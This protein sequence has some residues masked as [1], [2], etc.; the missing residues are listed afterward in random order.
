MT[1]KLVDATDIEGKLNKSLVPLD[2]MNVDDAF[3]IQPY[4]QQVN[5][6]K[7]EIEEL[8]AE[9]ADRSLLIQELENCKDQAR[10]ELQSFYER[11]ILDYEPVK[12]KFTSDLNELD[13]KLTGFDHDAFVKKVSDLLLGDLSSKKEKIASL[14]DEK[15]RDMFGKKMVELVI[16][17]RSKENNIYPSEVNSLQIREANSEKTKSKIISRT[18]TMKKEIDEILSLVENTPNIERLI[19]NLGYADHITK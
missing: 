19:E 7:Q 17:D 11:S 16:A 4:I 1:S 15:L 13:Y 3:D 9:K 8:N 5:H 12:V 10:A 6:I 18:D 2:D 14:V